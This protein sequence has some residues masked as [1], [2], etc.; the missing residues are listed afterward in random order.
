[1]EAKNLLDKLNAAILSIVQPRDAIAVKAMFMMSSTTFN[2]NDWDRAEELLRQVLQARLNML[3]PTCQD[4]WKCILNLGAV[5]AY[6]RQSSEA[7]KLLRFVLQ[8]LR[9]NPGAHVHHAARAFN[10]LASNYAIQGRFQEGE[11]VCRH[12]IGR[13]EESL[14]SDSRN[15]SICM[16]GWRGASCIEEDLKR[17]RFCSAPL[18]SGIPKSRAKAIAMH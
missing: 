5:L 15:F 12:A 17:A 6:Q 18:L 9:K 2:L 14:G 13:L 8:L 7:E 10:A 1:M 16:D 11:D 4:T 3:G